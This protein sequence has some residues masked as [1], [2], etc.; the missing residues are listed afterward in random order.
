MTREYLTTAEVSELTGIPV[1]TLRYW[2]HRRRGEGP[3]SFCL[4][5]RVA[6]SEVAE[7]VRVLSVADDA[8]TV[9]QHAPIPASPSREQYTMAIA[10]NL[11]L[12]A[13]KGATA[14]VRD[15]F[16]GV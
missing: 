3:K 16:G 14:E 2:R 4:G 15:T 12:D 11:A 9:D 5:R 6:Y 1:G 13:L 7:L 10:R 8:L